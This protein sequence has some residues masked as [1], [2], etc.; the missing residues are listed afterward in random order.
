MELTD[1]VA[2]L[3]AMNL[4]LHGI[5]PAGGEAIDPPILGGHDSLASDP[6]KRFNVVLTNPPFGKKSSIRVVNETGEEERQELEVYRE[7]FWA[8]T[9]NKQLNFVQHVKTLLA[10]NGRAAVVVPDNVLFEGGAGEV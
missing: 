10:I 8:T 6:A 9:K 7:D 4:T 1:A 3:C 2:R 5:G